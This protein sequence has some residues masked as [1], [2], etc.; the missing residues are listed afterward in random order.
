MISLI[1]EFLASSNIF[2]GQKRYFI[3]GSYAFN[4][5]IIWQFK[6]INY[7]TKI[8]FTK[9]KMLSSFHDANYTMKNIS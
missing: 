5:P 3:Y 1:K 2:F 9:N 7:Y 4:G 8:K 6:N